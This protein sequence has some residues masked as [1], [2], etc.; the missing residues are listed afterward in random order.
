MI[1]YRV[2]V[3]GIICV[4]V[5]ILESCVSGKAASKTT[6]NVGSFKDD[7]SA[8]RP[9]YTVSNETKSTE[10]PVSEPGK[11]VTKGKPVGDITQK[12]DVIL[13]TIAN[14]NKNIRFAQGYRVQIYS[15]NSSDEANRA[16]D[17]SYT[18]FPDITPHIVYVQPNFRVKVGDFIDRLEAQRVYVAL[19]AEFPTALI[20]PE[21]IEIR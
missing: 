15:G 19:K 18:L 9:V 5:G 21:R 11:P 13:D 3:L 20:V 1:S 6:S 10:T 16:R 14:T 8:Y 12:L 7:V 17:R 4:F 2:F